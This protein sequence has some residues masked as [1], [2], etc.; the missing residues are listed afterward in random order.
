MKTNLLVIS[1]LSLAA[2]SGC[3][4]RDAKM[5]QDDTGK[6]FAAKTPDIQACYDGVL[7]NDPKAAGKV[8]IAFE[9]ETEAGKIQSV[10]VEKAN[11]TAP[12]P[13]QECVTKNIANLSVQP[14]D[15]RL[16]QGKWV[17]EF[18]PKS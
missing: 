15:K 9:V 13:V 2:V 10:T 11:T 6:V 4:Y 12:E 14:P 17:W 1:A 7:K 3:A 8:T 18:S 5:W 16:G